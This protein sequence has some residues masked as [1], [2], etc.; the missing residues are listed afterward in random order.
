MA[1][2]AAAAALLAGH[3]SAGTVLF[4][5]FDADTLT[6]NWA[7]DSTFTSLGTVTVA[8]GQKASTDLIGNPDYY[9]FQPG[10][11]R[12][13]DLDGSTG[14]NNDP[15][16]VLQS[17]STFAAGT[18]TLT[19]DLA[20]NLRGAPA[21]T[22]TVSLGSWSV[23]LTPANNAGFNTFSYTFTTTGGNLT[24]L[25]HGP[26]NQQGNL[27]DNVRMNAV[28]EPSTWAMMLVGFAGLGGL[29]RARRKQGLAVA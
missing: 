9:D 19:F 14:S 26:S 2:F 13:V 5:N 3:A 6:L 27:L 18:Y 8:T 29:L 22:T 25:E 23:D 28:P 7:G 21:Q 12:Y 4:D 10:H 11:G 20:G 24:F 15:A 16:G 17:N 1:G